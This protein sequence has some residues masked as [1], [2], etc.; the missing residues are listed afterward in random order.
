[1]GFSELLEL[2]FH[3]VP[4]L[5][6]LLLFLFL[7]LFFDIRIKLRQSREEAADLKFNLEAAYK[8]IDELAAKKG[9]ES[10]EVIQLLHDLSGGHALIEVKRVSPDSF[11]LR[12]PTG[13]E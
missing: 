11:F 7:Y 10:Y 3:V 12:S 2:Q 4:L 6:F 1:M 5:S 13:G 9:K 8:R